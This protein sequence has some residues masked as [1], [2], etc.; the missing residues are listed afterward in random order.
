MYPQQVKN[1]LK[2]DE[3]SQKR[4]SERTKATLERA[5]LQVEKEK[6][7]VFDYT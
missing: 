1:K 6:S 2:K 7:G 4:E 5:K 3:I